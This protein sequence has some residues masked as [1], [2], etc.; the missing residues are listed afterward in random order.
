MDFGGVKI[1]R[2]GSYV[3]DFD[4]LTPL[5]FFFFKVSFPLQMQ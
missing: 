2:T 1:R 5:P 3:V 4:Y